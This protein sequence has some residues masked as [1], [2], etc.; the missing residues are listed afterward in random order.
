MHQNGRT[1]AE[2]H[3]ARIYS[4]QRVCVCVRGC[5]YMWPAH[6]RGSGIQGC[7]V[8]SAT[9]RVWAVRDQLVR[10]GF[11]RT[12]FSPIFIS[13]LLHTAIAALIRRMC[14]L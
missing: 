8:V 12:D 9:C 6:E 13:E 10:V 7:C 2:H 5:V 1:A 4:L 11:C 14:R 3:I